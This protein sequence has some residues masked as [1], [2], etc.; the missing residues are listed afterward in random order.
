MKDF[1]ADKSVLV[2][3][4]T[5]FKGSW[6]TLWLQHLG[7]NVIGYSLP[8]PTTPCMFEVAHVDRD[9]T[10]IQG[11]IRDIRQLKAAFQQFSPEIV[12][13]MAAQSLVRHSYQDPVETYMTNVMGTV[14]VF[15]A[16]R[17]TDSVGVVLN[18]TSDKCYENKEWV[19]G[20]R[21]NEPMGG[22]DPYSS[23]KG[24]A[25]LVTAAYRNSFFNGNVR[26]VLLASARAGNVIGGGDW[27]KDRLI[28]DIMQS[29]MRGY[30]VIL[31]NPAAI[32]PWQHVLEPLSGYLSLVQ[33]M[34]E[35]GDR[36]AGPWNFGPDHD[37]AKMV[38]WIADSILDIWGEG[39][40]WE[41]DN[42]PQPHEAQYL[43][44]DS[45]KARGRLGWKPK[46]LINEGLKWTVDW[47]KAY[48]NKHDMHEYTIDQII[49]Y[50]KR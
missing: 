13:H 9:M 7:A 28:P 31:R 16:V 48:Q 17:S 36:Y 50:E 21:E 34:Y 38:A 40:K 15:E 47:Y 33:R 8:P 44:L 49:N 30:T 20:Y 5:G 41:A 43:K 18:V 10:S 39:S 19:W 45:S 22:Y 32:R 46:S 25:E 11:D 35:Q 26:N 23:S 4:H 42:S 1:W 27:A 12:I 6:L 14:N 29:I 2:T 37:D 3:G 24:C